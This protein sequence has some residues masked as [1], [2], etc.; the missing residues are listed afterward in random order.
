MTIQSHQ[1]SRSQWGQPLSFQAFRLNL[2]TYLV[3]PFVLQTVAIV[4][5][6]GFL[7]FRHSTRAV[8]ELAGQLQDSIA[9]Q[10][11]VRVS[12]FL[13]TPHRVNQLNSNAASL[14]MISFDNIE[15]ARPFL[16]KQVNSF[17]DVGYSGLVDREGRFLRIGWATNR[18]ASGE[19]PQLAVQLRPGSGDLIYYSLDRAG[20]PSEV[21]KVRSNF[22]A[23]DSP[24]FKAA[25]AARRPTWGPVTV[26]FGYE[27]LQLNAVA[28]YFGAGG[29]ILGVF[30]TQISL[31]QI[32]QFLRSLKISRNSKVYIF[33]RNG[34]LIATS[35][36]NQPLIVGKGEQMQRVLASD[37]TDPMLR[38]AM[39]VLSRNLGEYSRVNESHQYEFNLEGK[40]ELMRVS[41]LEDGK[42]LQ[43]LLMV[44]TPEA[45]FM[46]Q[47]ESNSK[48]TIFLCI[49]SLMF[50]VVL[51]VA[52]SQ[53]VT[54][55]IEK[56]SQAATSL[57]EGDLNQTVDQSVIV[58][59]D[60]L[61]DSFNNMTQQLQSSFSALEQSN[62]ELTLAEENF[63]SIF[64]NA[65]DGIF[66]SSLQGRLLRA[67]PALA[68]IYGYNSTEEMKKSVK[69]V[70]RQFFQQPEVVQALEQQLELDGTV[71]DFVYSTLRVDG[72]SIWLELDARLVR[73]AVGKTLYLEGIVRNVTDRKLREDALERQLRELKIEI[74][75]SKK[76]QDVERLTSSTYFREAKQQIEDLD[77]ENFWS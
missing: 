9:K 73:D 59:I 77:L 75:Q 35:S 49:G 58:E 2:R 74:D 33:E 72:A 64:E 71:S 37:S 56:I 55:P 23:K 44:V 12:N 41:P 62:L 7:S 6:V 48:T 76:E 68:M 4:G 57:A 47:I 29:Q 25:V 1:A 69:D 51:G 61:A 70:D 8:N 46:G 32:S 24:L 34:Q 67:N 19:D 38:G 66:Q 3:V 11:S 36:S 26:N 22:D 53:W 52:S 40:R 16:W 15:A 13:S 10:V 31:D 39:E 27:N 21:E 65:Q 20:N 63:R 18:L 28:P 42:G 60:Q 30:N 45:D 43:W 14:G 54:K 50:A 5:L 17:A